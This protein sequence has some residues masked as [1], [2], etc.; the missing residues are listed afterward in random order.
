L[1]WGDDGI[2]RFFKKIYLNLHPGGHLLLEP[3][4]WASYKKK[5]KL[6]VCPDIFGGF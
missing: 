6:T 2:K 5:A 3:Q 4:S 1:N